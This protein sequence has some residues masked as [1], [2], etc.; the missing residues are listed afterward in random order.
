MGALC[1]WV[2]FPVLHLA[3]SVGL[4]PNR[5]ILLV[6]AFHKVLGV[7][8]HI[9]QRMQLHLWRPG[10]NVNF[11]ETEIKYLFSLFF[12]FLAIWTFPKVVQFATHHNQTL[13]QMLQSYANTCWC[14][15]ESRS[16]W[17][18]ASCRA[19]ACVSHCATEKDCSPSLILDHKMGT[20]AAISLRT[21]W[22]W[23]KTRRNLNSQ[24]RF[25]RKN[26]SRAKLSWYIKAVMNV[27]YMWDNWESEMLWV[28]QLNKTTSTFWGN[29]FSAFLMS[30]RRE[31]Q[32][33][34]H[35]CPFNIELQL[36]DC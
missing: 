28:E 14:S 30:V 5:K 31:D 29:M 23:H 20:N 36:R 27:C 8:Q 24:W 6:L 18:V 35:V 33:H 3:P 9:P 10:R 13:M 1:H 26:V 22:I 2:V 7:T 34:L 12:C 15:K 32:H 21:S 4:L 19:L 25:V 16:V 17:W 11:W